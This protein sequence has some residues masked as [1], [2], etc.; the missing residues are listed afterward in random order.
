MW[1]VG[2]DLSASKQRTAGEEDIDLARREGW[3]HLPQKDTLP[4]LLSTDGAL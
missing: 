3:V 4:A 2:I 1:T